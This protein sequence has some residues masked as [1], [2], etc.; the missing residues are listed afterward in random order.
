MGLSLDLQVLCCPTCNTPQRKHVY[1]LDA[2][3]RA[4]CVHM[5]VRCA[6][7]GTSSGTC[8]RCSTPSECAVGLD[9]LQ[10]YSQ[11]ATCLRCLPTTLPVLGSAPACFALGAPTN[12]PALF[13][14]IFSTRKPDALQDIS[15]STNICKAEYMHAAGKQSWQIC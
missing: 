4:G 8:S 2:V 15:E 3:H 1:W 6:A 12:M 7:C 14:I 13:C 9:A 5:V 11:P 10:L